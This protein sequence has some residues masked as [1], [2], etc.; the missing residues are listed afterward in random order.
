MFGGITRKLKLKEGNPLIYFDCENISP[1]FFKLIYFLRSKLLHEKSI[2]YLVMEIPVTWPLAAGMNYQFPE[3]GKIAGVKLSGKLIL[4][5]MEIVQIFKGWKL[6]KL[7]IKLN[8]LLKGWKSKKY[9]FKFKISRGRMFQYFKNWVQ[10][11]KNPKITF[12]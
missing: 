11:C 2:L 7:D 3:C 12:D 5:W 8:L 4:K 10:L 6:Q 1:V 9:F